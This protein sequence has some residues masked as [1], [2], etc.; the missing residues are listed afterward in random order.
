MVEKWLLQVEDIMLASIRKQIEEAVIAYPITN[1]DKWVLDWPGQVVLCGSQVF[2]TVEMEEAFKKENG[3]AVG[4][5]F[6]VLG[7][8]SRH[9]TKWPTLYRHFQMYFFEWKYFYLV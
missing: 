4:S 9:G 7:N 5:A 8:S 6:M 1:R 2:W 3:I